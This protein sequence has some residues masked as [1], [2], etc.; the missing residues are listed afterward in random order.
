MPWVNTLHIGT[1]SIIGYPEICSPCRSAL[2]PAVP[3]MYDVVGGVIEYVATSNPNQFIHFGGDELDT[4]CWKQDANL[5]AWMK[6]KGFT[7]YDQV[8][9]YFEKFVISTY[10]TYNKTMVCWQELLLN[11]NHT[12]IN[13]PKDTIVQAWINPKALLSIVEQGYRALLSAGWYFD[14][15]YPS[16]VPHYEWE[17]TWKGL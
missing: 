15:Q 6:T 8:L 11:Y 3:S 16:S 17:D 4:N 2:S 7:N 5:N 14:Q 10:Q 12:I 13:L 9:G 1:Y